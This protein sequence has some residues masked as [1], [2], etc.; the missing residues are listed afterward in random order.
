MGTLP[1]RRLYASARGPVLE[2]GDLQFKC[3]RMHA[4]ILAISVQLTYTGCGIKTTSQDKT[5]VYFNVA[6]KKLD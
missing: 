4:L 3:T 2:L 5:S 1:F 6:V